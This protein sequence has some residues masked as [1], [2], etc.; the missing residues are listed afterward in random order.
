MIETVL[1][2]IGFFTCVILGVMILK[3]FWDWLFDFIDN[4][5]ATYQARRELR[6][7]ADQRDDLM[8]ENKKLQAALDKLT[9][10]K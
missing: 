3:A 8:R 10:E 1:A 5:T 6:Y 7:V 2:F 4:A 9:G